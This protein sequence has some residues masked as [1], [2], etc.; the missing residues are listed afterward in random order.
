MKYA[1]ESKFAHDGMPCGGFSL[2]NAG[3]CVGVG[4]WVRV[5]PQ[6]PC[7]VFGLLCPLQL[8]SKKPMKPPALLYLDNMYK[9]NF[10][11]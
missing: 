11:Y 6:W 7:G 10:S 9:R 3:F 8:K 5:L 2:V 4:W 1:F